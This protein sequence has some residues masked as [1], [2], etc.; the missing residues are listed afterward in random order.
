MA[1]S[2]ND[3]TDAEFSDLLHRRQRR[4]AE[5]ED[6]PPI[7]IE[8]QS[9]PSSH[10]NSET[11]PGYA[12]HSNFQHYPPMYGPPPYFVDP[13]IP[14]QED[15]SLGR[16]LAIAETRLQDMHVPINIWTRIICRHLNEQCR[17]TCEAKGFTDNTPW[18]SVRSVLWQRYE[19]NS[20]LRGRLLQ[21]LDESC[22]AN[23][24]NHLKF[25][26]Q[27]VSRDDLF[28]F[29][30]EKKCSPGLWSQIS[31]FIDTRNLSITEFFL[32]A[33]TLRFQLEKAAQKV[34]T[35]N[36][37][38]SMQSANSVHFNSSLV[39][40]KPLCSHCKKIGHTVNTCFIL[41]PELK[42]QSLISKNVSRKI[43]YY[44]MDEPVEE[45]TKIYLKAV[46]SK[47]NLFAGLDT[48]A[49]ANLI[50][51]KTVESLNLSIKSVPS[52]SVELS[53]RN[54]NSSSLI[55]ENVPILIGE[56][57]FPVS[58]VV[59]GNLPY[60][61][62]C[63]LC[64]KSIRELN[65][66]HLLLGEDVPLSDSNKNVVSYFSAR[67]SSLI[68]LNKRIPS[69][70]CYSSQ[71]HTVS[72]ETPNLLT[73]IFNSRKNHIP[74]SHFNQVDNILEKWEEEGRIEKTT[75]NGWCLPLLTVPKPNGTIRLC[76]NTKKLNSFV[77]NSPKC[78]VP[79]IS[80]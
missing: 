25:V 28:L 20:Q 31:N 14:F 68:E 39:P 41:H 32:K 50:S 37:V 67:L 75:Y 24:L 49:E 4:S 10:Q 71:S 45:M 58:F 63:I 26:Y 9:A 64:K 29:W 33:D 2:S 56:K 6:S 30:M 61:L 40:S 70:D 47:K 73:P 27:K 52:I 59:I 72:I 13:T 18:E 77:T 57:T 66:G 48:G 53:G 42:S 12:H 16:F 17:L 15:L 7:H 65:L 80:T 23:M 69:R 22:Q 78:M 8:S 54:L 35:P 46:D 62:D 5:C 21:K 44:P 1:S 76:L 3:L 43:N 51:K 55:V 60:G 19:P 38:H 11:L 34:T 36:V 74:M 79:R